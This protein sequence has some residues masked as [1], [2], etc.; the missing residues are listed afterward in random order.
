ML[1]VSDRICDEGSQ[2]SGTLDLSS[3]PC[4][5]LATIIS[6]TTPPDACT[7]SVVSTFFKMAADSDTVWTKFLPPDYHHLIPASLAN[8]PKKHLYLTLCDNPVLIENGK[9][10]FSLDKKS[11]KK[12]YMLAAR[13]LTIIWSDTPMYWTWTNSYDSRFDEVA[14]L[15]FVWWFEI[16]GRINT[17]MLSPMTPYKA[18]LVLK[19]TDGAYGFRDYNDDYIPY[20]AI[21]R[22][23]GIEVSKRN[24]F[25]DAHGASSWFEIELGEF[26]NER[27]EDSELDISIMETDGHRKS[28]LI[29]QGIEIR[30]AY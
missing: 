6:F 17:C 27:G 20:E 13:D 1:T 29:I 8:L 3:I 11:G 2:A 26:F 5:W 12:C 4:D 16:R 25:V 23:S 15:Q 7:L 9:K 22:L 10:S 14:E 24:V 21:I 30:P 19:L 18:Y 28:G